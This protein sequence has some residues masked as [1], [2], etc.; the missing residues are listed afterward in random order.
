MTSNPNYYQQLIA[1]AIAYPN[2]ATI[3]IQLDLKRTFPLEKDPD[4]LSKLTGPLN[5]VLCAYV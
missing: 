2:P 5:N 3:Q 1:Q 4:T